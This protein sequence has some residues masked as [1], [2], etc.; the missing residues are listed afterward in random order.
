MKAREIDRLVEDF[1]MVEICAQRHVLRMKVP[2]IVFALGLLGRHQL[3][4]GQV[5]AFAQ[6]LQALLVR[7][8]ENAV[9]SIE[10]L[11]P[12]SSRRSPGSARAAPSAARLIVLWQV[13]QPK[14]RRS[15]YGSSSRSSR[16]RSTVWKKPLLANFLTL[17]AMDTSVASV[18]ASGSKLA[19]ERGRPAVLGAGDT[20]CR[21]R[22]VSNAQRRELAHLARAMRRPSTSATSYPR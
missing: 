6:A 3:H 17:L 8:L 9:Q 5:G 1:P 16:S 14:G 18:I 4:A 21:C 20:A 15:A 10:Q 11:R 12:G 13:D 2:T 19:R 22:R 7:Q